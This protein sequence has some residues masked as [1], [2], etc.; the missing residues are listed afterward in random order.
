VWVGP[1]YWANRLQDWRVRDGHL[2]CVADD[3]R[4][5]MRTVHLLTDE[6]V[7]RHG[8]FYIVLDVEQVVRDRPVATDSAAGVLVGAGGGG[9][10]WRSSA[11]VH[12]WSGP[13][14]GLFAGLTADGRLVLHDRSRR[15]STPR[16]SDVVVP[17]GEEGLWIQLATRVAA[18]DSYDLRLSAHGGVT[19]DYGNL[20]QYD[21][22]ELTATVPARRLVG[23]LAIVSHPGTPAEGESGGRWRYWHWGFGG[24]PF[25]THPERSFGP[26]A[27]VQYTASRGVL[28]LTAQMLP[29]GADEERS[30][31]LD[32]W[33]GESWKEVAR[34]DVVEPGFTAPFR[35]DGWDGGR[36]VRYRVVWSERAFEGAIRG[37]PEGDEVVLAGMNC[38]HNNSH[39]LGSK[40]T[41]WT[42]QIWFPHADLVAN[43]AAQDPDLLFFAGDQVYEGKSPTFPDR[44]HLELDY[45]YKWYLWCWAYRDLTRDIPTVTIPD[46][47][48]V[49]QGNVWGEGGRVAKRDN[50][51]G[52]V[53]PAS[54]VKMVE[55]TQTSHLPDPFDPTPIE[56]GIGSYHTSLRLGRVDF[57]VLEDRKFKSGPAGK[58]LPETGTKRPDHVDREAFDPREYD[59]RDLVLLG[60]RQ[61]RFLEHWAADWD[62]VEMKAVLSQSPFANLATHHGANLQYLQADLDSNGWPQSGRDRAVRALRAAFAFH[63]SGDQHLATLVQHG[64]DDFGDAIWS[65]C[66]PSVANFYPRA[67][68]PDGDPLG[69]H[70]DGLG[71]RVTVH[72][73]ANP[74]VDTGLEPSDLYDKMPGYGIVR[75][76]V[77]EHTIR[78]E[79]WP[80]HEGPGGTQYAGW[81]RTI[82]QADNAPGLPERALPWNR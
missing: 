14:A 56:Q 7:D 81:P 78:F 64:V 30:V 26:V 11:L 69:D 27:T 47:H 61:L 41:D 1:T 10:D 32:T 15:D 57:A 6:L 54:F 20:T 29:I 12:Q 5:G 80:R 65:F 74:G 39:R 82:R 25:D 59:R 23:G 8:P 44:E 75:M 66:V 49:Y 79:C 63:V 13:G 17:P 19:D 67:W 36:D 60:E 33:D 3:P 37:D 4:L 40:E 70:R 18:D 53:H 9:G 43:V 71:N 22:G 62:G 35:V 45:L 16:Y 55:R 46:D 76:N 48:D 77:K 38:N 50:E 34:T 21:Y 72:A 51:G 73:V 68:R 2:E 24:T 52:Y 42:S 28:K 58:G 31:R